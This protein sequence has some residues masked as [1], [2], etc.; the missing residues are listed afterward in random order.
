MRKLGIALGAGIGVGLLLAILFTSML[1]ASSPPPMPWEMSDET[2]DLSRLPAQLPA[3]DCNGNVVA[4]LANPLAPDAP[5]WIPTDS[6]G[7]PCGYAGGTTQW[8][9]PDQH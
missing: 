3:L 5:E 7:Q 2:I 4:T 8:P 9:P 1:Q 6:N